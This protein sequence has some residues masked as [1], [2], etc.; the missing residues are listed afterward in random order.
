M[1]TEKNIL[2]DKKVNGPLVYV[3]KSLKFIHEKF[4]EKKRARYPGAIIKSNSLENFIYEKSVPLVGEFTSSTQGQYDNVKLP[5]VI[6]F[7]DFDHDRNEKH[8]MYLVNRVRRVAQSTLERLSS[9]LRIRRATV[10]SYAASKW[11]TS[12]VT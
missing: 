12:P 6:A 10:Q 9:P 4:G 2:E 8:Y 5:L 1:V 7:G 3:Y 11:K